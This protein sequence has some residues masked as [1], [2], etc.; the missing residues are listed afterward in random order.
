METAILATIPDDQDQVPSFVVKNLNIGG[1]YTVNPS[2]A[3]LYVGTSHVTN[4]ICLQMQYIINSLKHLFDLGDVQK[5]FRIGVLGCGRVGSSA[6]QHLIHSSH[7]DPS[8]FYVGTRQPKSQTCLK[9]SDLGVHISDDNTTA[10]SRVRVLLLAC[11][12]SQMMEVA[13]SVTG[14]IRKST[15]ILSV[16]PGFSTNKISK[17]LRLED[18]DMVLRIG[19]QVPVSVVS[20]SL[21]EYPSHE[22]MSYFAGTTLLAS[23]THVQRLHVAFVKVCSTVLKPTQLTDD[24]GRAIISTRFSNQGLICQALYGT[25][26]DPGERASGGIEDSRDDERK[27]CIVARF[28][29][30]VFTGDSGDGDDKRK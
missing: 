5:S 19:C 7:I 21:G 11:L 25:H 1:E 24:K 4:L 12:P 29:D 20:S 10:T 22:T 8:T 2:L 13:R 14:S 26:V 27:K 6:I 23:S 9:L 18:S 17:M 3:S 16:V 28:M 15:L 30:V